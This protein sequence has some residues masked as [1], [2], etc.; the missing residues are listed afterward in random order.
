VRRG[1]TNSG[2]GRDV[3]WVKWWHRQVAQVLRFAQD[4]NLQ[5]IS[6]DNLEKI[7]GKSLSSIS[8]S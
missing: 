4:D 2:G 5:K 1:R 6:E 7:S 3:G 8:G